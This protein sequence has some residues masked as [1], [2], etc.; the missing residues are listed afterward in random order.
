MRNRYTVQHRRY[1]TDTTR[2][3]FSVEHKEGEGWTRRETLASTTLPPDN[4]ARQPRDNFVNAGWCGGGRTPQ[5]VNSVLHSHLGIF[6]LFS[7]YR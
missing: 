7:S 2:P 4:Y 1:P 3:Y 5:D 6:P